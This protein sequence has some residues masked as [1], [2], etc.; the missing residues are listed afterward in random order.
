M[1]IYGAEV[2][3]NKLLNYVKGLSD[4]KPRMYQKSKVRL[5]ELA[6]TCNQVVAVISEI[7]QDEALVEENSS[8]EFG[9]SEFSDV[10]SVLT[11]ME[12]QLMELRKFL[13]SPVK[14]YP[15][16]VILPPASVSESNSEDHPFGTS[17]TK[18]DESRTIDAPSG[19]KKALYDYSTC[20]EK[21]SETEM[22]VSEAEGCSKLLWDWFNTRFRTNS[23][24]FKYNMKKFPSWLRDIV[25]LYCYHLEQNTLDT[26]LSGFYTWMSS[27]PTRNDNYS[28]PYEVFQFDKNPD[29]NK[30]TLS[31]LVMWDI[32]LDYGLRNL[33]LDFSNKL[34]PT[35]DLVYNFVNELNEKVMDP[36]KNYSYD[37]SI[38]NICGF[39]VKEDGEHQ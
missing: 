7:L 18:S 23:G 8:D 6:N 9:G 25:I 14:R 22:V 30:M 36:Y 13:G 16:E 4:S 5:K 29:S 20:L 2:Q 17:E 27:L 32:L 28:V 35:E 24:N 39:H 33:C 34:Y 1:D 26:F 11:S 15:P 19:K 3:V 21:L 37:S 31:A 10:N 38:L 12:D